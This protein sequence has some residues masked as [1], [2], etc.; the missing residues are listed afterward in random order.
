MLSEKWRIKLLGG[1]EVTGSGERIDRFRGR[2]SAELLALL[3]LNSHRFV[4]REEIAGTIWPDSTHEAG[5]AG[6][7]TALASLRAQLEP[8]GTVA[9]SVLHADRVGLRLS[10]D[11]FTADVIEFNAASARAASARSSESRLAAALQ[12][13]ELYSGELLPGELLRNGVLVDNAKN[14]SQMYWKHPAG[15]VVSRYRSCDQPSLAVPYARSLILENPF[16]EEPYLLTMRLCI[17]AGCRNEALSCF[18]Q[19]TKIVR[20]EF[21]TTP[22][23]AASELEQ[24][25]RGMSVNEQMSDRGRNRRSSEVPQVHAS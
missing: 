1:L 19:L 22:S 8:P 2:T 17:E 14:Y 23:D 5:R 11:A 20:A 13:V 6:L 10:A 25:A 21:E 15:H 4:A 16:D 7:R 3:V 12:A 9:N 18:D 24:L